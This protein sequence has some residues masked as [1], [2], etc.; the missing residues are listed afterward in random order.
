V[1]VTTAL[2]NVLA[3]PGASV[4]GVRVSGEG[5]IVSV[6]L[7]RRRMACS[8]CGQLCSATHDRGLR[9][10]RHL[11]LAGYRCFVQCELRRVSCGVCGVRVEAVPW[12]R[13]GARHTREFEQ[14]VAFCAQRM[15]KSHVQALLRIAWETVGRIVTRVVADQL[16]QQRLQG[17][18]QIGVD[19]I[20]YRRGHRYLTNVADHQTGAIIWSAP[21][22]GGGTLE[23]FFAS[24]GERKASIRAVSIDMSEPYAGAIRRSL[25]QAEIA[26]DPFHVIALATVAVDQVRRQHARSIGASLDVGGTWIKH[27]RWALLKGG[28][29]LSEHQRL[30]LAGIQA[31]N[32]PL[33]RA[34]LLKEQLRALYRLPDPTEASAH[35]DAWLAWA[36][37]SQLTPFTKLARTLSRHRNGILTAIRLG[38]TN[39]RLEGLHN[40]IRLLC[41]RSYGLRSPQALIALIHLCCGRLTIT[42][43]QR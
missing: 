32:Q 11:D 3:L 7:R 24:L 37:R 31:T 16:D 6:R 30:T 43:P 29:H 27:A 41:H 9:R 1:R 15:A 33:Y 19:E 38:L 40:K 5:V 26:F 13:P 17:L 25:P 28:E 12:A 42:P 34:Y 23:Q 21:G 35:L 14:L 2:N 39:A 20:S 8:V 36:Q 10:W 22:R 18:V 4:T